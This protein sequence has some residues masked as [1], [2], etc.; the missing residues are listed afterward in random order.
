MYT[1]LKIFVYLPTKKA[2]IMEGTLLETVHETE[3]TTET[4]TKAPHRRK[5]THPKRRSTV[6]PAVCFSRLVKELTG[7]ASKKTKYI[8]STT[9]MQALQESAELHMQDRFEKCG[10]LAT[11]CNKQTVTPEIFNFKYTKSS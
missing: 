10:D 11:L 2:S 9:A 6:I 8:W 3:S 4:T 7:N 1:L 5:N